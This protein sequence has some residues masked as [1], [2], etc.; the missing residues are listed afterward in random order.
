VRISFD[1]NLLVY[2]TI[3]RRERRPEEARALIAR[4]GRAE[5]ATLILQTL[6]EFSHVAIRKSGL[7]V[8]RTR[9]VIQDWRS[10]FPVE[11]ALEDDLYDAL[12]TVRDHRLSFYDALLWATARR[13][14]VTHLLSED[15]QDGR[16][17]GGVRF[18]NPFVD[19]N[20]AIIDR[21]FD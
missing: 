10:N 18:V 12:D 5:N 19:A 3:P 1:T 21:L 9:T 15:F 11:P 14:G 17:L 6:V 8:E 2:A 16:V 13:V 7:P 4:A 20:A